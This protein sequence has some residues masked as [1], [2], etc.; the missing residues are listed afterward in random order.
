V[1][2]LEGFIN[3]EVP[4]A[5][6]TAFEKG[7]LYEQARL[8]AEKFRPR[9]NQ[10]VAGV[11]A[12]IS[13][14]ALIFDWALSKTGSTHIGSS[15]PIDPTTPD[16]HYRDD[17]GRIMAFV[18]ALENDPGTLPGVRTA[19][20]KVREDLATERDEKFTTTPPEG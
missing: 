14:T 3:L 8:L 13:T 19:W 7:Q 11:F 9:G 17:L 1:K 12:N 6:L 2:R 4:W 20:A 18:A 15:V 10:N 5:T 16:D